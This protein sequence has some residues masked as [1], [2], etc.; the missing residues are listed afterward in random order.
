MVID[1]IEVPLSL[2]VY[3]HEHPIQPEA[4]GKTIWVYDNPG[5]VFVGLEYTGPPPDLERKLVLLPRYLLA[6]HTGPYRDL[7]ATYDLLR[8]ALAEHGLRPLGV[9]VEIRGPERGA[10]TEVDVLI[11][12][13][14]N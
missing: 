3:G 5:T 7:P 11:G 1:L 14:R 2:T 6:Q 10:D 8:L 12:L 13:A 4:S 9:N